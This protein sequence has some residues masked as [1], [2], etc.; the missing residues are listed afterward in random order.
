[1]TKKFCDRCRNEMPKSVAE[2]TMFLLSEGST[3]GDGIP[4]TVDVVAR[5]DR[6]VCIPCRKEIVTKG[7]P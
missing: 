3:E 2:S 1:M 6:D 4:W 7:K 5:R